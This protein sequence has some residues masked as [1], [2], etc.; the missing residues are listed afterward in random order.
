MM[1]QQTGH[2]RA[3]A[4]E[5]GYFGGKKADVRLISV[6]ANRTDCLFVG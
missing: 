4:G 1:R 2:D 3:I 6:F 5:H